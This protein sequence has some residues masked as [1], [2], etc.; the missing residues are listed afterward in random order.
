MGFPPTARWRSRIAPAP[1]RSFRASGYERRA[2]H[3][4]ERNP[5]RSQ[6]NQSP[7]QQNPSRGQQNPNP[8]Q[9]N[10]NACSFLQPRLFNRLRLFQVT[11]A[12]FRARNCTRRMLRMR[13]VVISSTCASASL[14]KALLL[15]SCP[16]ICPGYYSRALWT[17]C[18]TGPFGFLRP[19]DVQSVSE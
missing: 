14:E 2:R 19:S 1:S 6:H 18:A 11:G 15:H 8:A 10:P 16:G 4:K 13:V 7:A 5:N 3:R 17:I 12:D 9:Q